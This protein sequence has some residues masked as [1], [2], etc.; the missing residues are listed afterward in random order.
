MEVTSTALHN[1]IVAEVQL[2]YKSKVKVPNAPP[3]ITLTEPTTY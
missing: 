1:I 2:V 3:S